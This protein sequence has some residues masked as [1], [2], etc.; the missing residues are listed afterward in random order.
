MRLDFVCFVKNCKKVHTNETETGKSMKS[1]SENRFFFHFELYASH[2]I[3]LYFKRKTA[4][5]IIIS[6]SAFA[7][8]KVVFARI[9]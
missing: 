1:A 4:Y 3:V 8:E 2:I 5:K 7:S 6:V 9:F